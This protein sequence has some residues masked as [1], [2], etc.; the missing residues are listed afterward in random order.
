MNLNY[1]KKGGP[2]SRRVLLRRDGENLIAI[3]MLG[4]HHVGKSLVRLAK[5]ALRDAGRVEV[6][7]AS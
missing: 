5:K 6:K 7:V 1:G 4:G 3:V 2:D